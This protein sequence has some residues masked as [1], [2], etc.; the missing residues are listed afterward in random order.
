MKIIQ[1]IIQ[2]KKWVSIISGVLAIALFFGVLSLSQMLPRNSSSSEPQSSSQLSSLITSVFSQ[3]EESAALTSSPISAD[4]QSEESSSASSS[5][6]QSTEIKG[7]VSNT[8]ATVQSINQSGKLPKFKSYTEILALLKKLGVSYD[9]YY[10]G[11]IRMDDG[12]FPTESQNDSGSPTTGGAEKGSDYSS[13]N[14]QVSGIDEGDIIKN[15]GQY[16]YIA[17]QNTVSIIKAFPAGEMKKA[18]VITLPQEETVQ[19]LYLRD[20]L[21]ALVCYSYEQIKIEPVILPEPTIQ[22]DSGPDTSDAAISETEPGKM[23]AMPSI[24]YMSKQL[25]VIK[26]YNITDRTAP[27]LKRTLKFDGYLTASRV[28]DGKFYLVTNQYISSFPESQVTAE[29]ILPSYLDSAAGKNEIIIRAE[30]IEYCPENVSANFL[31][32]SFFD[33]DNMEPAVVETVLGAGNTVYMSNTALYIVQPYYRYF[34]QGMA[35]AAGSTTN[36]GD[37]AAGNPDVE[38]SADEIS[39]DRSD[40]APS[41][42]AVSKNESGSSGSSATIEPVEPVYVTDEGTVVMKFNLVENGVKFSIAGEVHGQVLNQYSMDEFESTFRIATTQWTPAGTANNLYAL[43]TA[44]MKVVGKIENLAPGERI[45]SVRFIGKTGYIVTF[46]NMDPLFVIDLSNPAAPKVVGELKIPG[47]SNYLHPVSATLLMGIGQH[48]VTI[49]KKDEFGND[50]EVGSQ[51][52]GLKVSL[53]DVS[54][55]AEPKEVSSLIFGGV[56]SNTEAQYNPKAFVWWGTKATALF[57][58]YIYGE[59]GGTDYDNYNDARSGGIVVAVENGKLVEKARLFPENISYGYYGQSRVVYIDNA[60]YISMN[61]SVYA[62][63]VSTLKEI[64]RI[65]MLQ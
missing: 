3:E 5:Q 24:W 48:T 43:N 33:M 41:D 20:N 10:R 37:A 28:K 12:M 1:T 14:T 35:D 64:S 50:V 2:N 8:K 52:S 36:V 42:I 54:D 45:Y 60:I 19:E 55:P 27:V 13:T 49:Y 44:T 17:N 26:I 59:D 18:G 15:D 4:G 61:G 11:D 6:S 51:Q 56:G 58:A 65:A 21:L 46:R 63:D 31:M 34:I 38:V 30:A 39:P 47:F 29:D 25:T 23:D 32:V 53:F 16:L 62:Y 57:P 22:V 40:T 7:N 9:G